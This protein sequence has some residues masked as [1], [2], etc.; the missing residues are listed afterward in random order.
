MSAR[1]ALRWRNSVA[2]AIAGAACLATGLPG[3]AAPASAAVADDCPAAYPVSEL[4]DGLVGSGLTVDRGNVANPFMATYVGTIDD[5]I[6][7]DVDMIIMELDSPALRKAGGVWSGMSGSPVYAPDGRLIGAVSYGL[8]YGPSLIAG[9]TPAA[10]MLALLARTAPAKAPAQRVSLPS[11]VRRELVAS[12]AATS[13]AAAA[14]MRQL[15][16]PLGLST[17]SRRFAAVSERLQKKLPNARPFSMG[18]ATAASGDAPADIF[19]GSNLA[20]T[21]AYGDFNAAAVGTTTAVCADDV[22]IGFG[23]PLSYTGSSA[24]S[25]HPAS[26][27]FV[28]P[29]SAAAPFKVANIGL[30]IGTLDQDRTAGVRAHFRAVPG[31]VPI[32]SRVTAVGGMSRAGR[33]DVVLQDWV[34]DAGSEHAY[35]NLDRVTDGSSGG[36]ARL[37]MTVKGQRASGRP[38]TLSLANRYADQYDTLS[39]PSFEV[40]E[41]LARLGYNPYEDVRIT[42]V[43][44]TASVSETYTEHV[45]GA[46]HR[47]LPNGRLVRLDPEKPLS[48]EAGSRLN[49]RVQLTPYR[50]HGTATSV[51]VSV[52]VP[53]ATAGNVAMLMVN[54][55]LGSDG[56]D[57][58]EGIS[59]GPEES[60]DFDDLLAALA[61]R[62]PNNSVTATVGV[63]KDNGENFSYVERS[64]RAATETV[65]SGGAY[66]PLRVV[67]PRA[68]T[69]GVVDRA[70]WKLRPGLS[71]GKPSRTFTFGRVGDQH[72][73]GDWDGD[74]V[75][76]P[77][78]FRNGRWF[79]RRGWAQSTQ[80][81]LS[82][83]ARG[84][85][86][87]AGDWDGDGKDSIGVFRRGRWFLRNSLTTGTADRDFSFGPANARPV[88]GD[89]DGDGVDTI[90]TFASGRWA[91]RNANSAG[92][93]VRTFRFGRAGDLP[94]AVEWDGD[95]ADEPALFRKGQWLLRRSMTQGAFQRR[96]VYGAA[97]S[98]PVVGG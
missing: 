28:Q 8:S 49:L 12:G 39:S 18:S 9:V 42:S 72:L 20:A 36:T 43:D 54:G 87:V 78:V 66:F 4:A 69:V 77:A 33:T 59:S 47:R 30:P 90:A 76:T 60:G 11:A 31:T 44:M 88:V 56:G 75:K 37:A 32:T 14:G 57:D 2:A 63:E 24:L 62:A 50:N 74:G 91:F 27:V 92:A 19:P 82:F 23:H 17:S 86:A 93:A 21:I 3:S 40:Y 67:A 6:G 52:I 53:A 25:V 38:F 26:A 65:V 29:D 81:S 10:D 68:S 1:P 61:N 84:D 95:G 83:G 13:A 71:G 16:V 45:V 96:V 58:E 73:M 48:A 35:L 41:V 15:P 55:G 80:V 97:T 79:V 34:P 22:V 85:L 89:W 64:S 70:T 51:D 5:G 46:V 94:L 98:R 7:T